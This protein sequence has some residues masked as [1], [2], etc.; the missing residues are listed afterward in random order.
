MGAAR[1]E[2]CRQGHSCAGKNHRHGRARRLARVGA[3]TLMKYALGQRLCGGVAVALA[4]CVGFAMARSFRPAVVAAGWY[5]EILPAGGHKRTVPREYL[6]DK[7]QAVLVD[8]A[9]W[10]FLRGHSPR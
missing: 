5:G 3:S 8:G 6:H 1:G 2:W 10:V 4:V 9:A 7:D